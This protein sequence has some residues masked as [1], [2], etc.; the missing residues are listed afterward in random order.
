MSIVKDAVDSYV[1]ANL[2]N[3]GPHDRTTT[4]GASEIG[5]CERKTWFNKA[6]QTE[7]ASTFQR[8]PDYVDSWGARLRGDIVENHLLV[9]ALRRY[10]K[11]AKLLGKQQKT[12]VDGCISATPDCLIV[13]SGGKGEFLI[14]CKSI[15]PRVDKSSLPK[16]EHVYQV[17]VQMG[18]LHAKSKWRPKFAIVAYVNASFMDEITEFEIE[19]DPEI[20]QRASV[21][22][23]RIMTA[24]SHH[25][26][27]PEGWIAGGRECEY[28]PFTDACGRARKEVPAQVLEPADKQFIAEI[29]DMAQEY[30][31][32]ESDLARLEETRRGLQNSI[33]ERLR[34]KGQ[35]RIVGDGVSI[36]WATVKGRE[37]FDMA[38]IRE[39]L[40]EHGID[41]DFYKREGTPGDRLTVTLKPATMADKARVA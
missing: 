34:E 5:Q 3:M 20:Y 39:V 16:P 28:C 12:F 30:K 40:T 26:L 11:G 25:E 15:D 29:S 4:V 14:E 13:P 21:R 19:Y 38:T 6:E 22:A 35:N 10:N 41:M 17:Q 23:L 8:N 9:P 7:L 18:I 36:S 33:K 37:T 1:K 31:I 24:G 2:K 27:Q 32:V